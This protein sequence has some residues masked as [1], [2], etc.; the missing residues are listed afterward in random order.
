MPP[1]DRV[2]IIVCVRVSA[3]M[4]RCSCDIGLGESDSIFHR[5]SQN[6][7]ERP[8]TRSLPSIASGSTRSLSP[9]KKMS[10]G[11]GV[12]GGAHERRI[13]GGSGDSSDERKAVSFGETGDSSRT[14]QMCA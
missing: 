13:S 12:N 10:D 2:H 11:R 9:H 14:G 7:F 5:T 8:T 1:S 3:R 6:N 4:C